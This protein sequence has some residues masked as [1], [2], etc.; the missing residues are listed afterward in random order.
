MI[1][2]ISKS[3]V[4]DTTDLVM[5]WLDKFSA[6]YFRLNGDDFID[7]ADIINGKIY[8]E[9][10]NTKTIT[11]IWNRRWSSKGIINA[12]NEAY[13]DN[14]GAKNASILL[15]SLSEETGILRS[16]LMLKL[17]SKVW[18]TRPE[19]MSANKIMNLEIAKSCNLS[20]PEYIITSSKLTLSK[21]AKHHER[22]ISKPISETPFFSNSFE[23]EIV[24]TLIMYTKSFTDVFIEKEFPKFFFKSLFQQEII[25][26]FEIRVFYLNDTCYAMAIFSQ[27]DKQTQVDFRNYNTNKPNRTV[28]FNLPKAVESN[29]KKFCRKA[30]YTIGSLD[31]IKSTDGKYYFLEINPVGQFGM[32]SYPCNYYLE[33]KLAKY[34]IY[35]NEK[36][37]S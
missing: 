22:I 2:I 28:P 3:E 27:N 24:E 4:E 10:F 31:L 7:K 29:I 1:L 8:L 6:G 21:F 32:V 17:A 26:E 16:Y 37:S 33:K 35:E 25:K 19:K 34:L 13:Y 12:D 20:V 11:I 5:D 30:S 14:L 18:T 23:N 9:N 15:R 36:R